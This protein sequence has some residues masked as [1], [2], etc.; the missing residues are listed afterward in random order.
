MGRQVG[1]N[2]NLPR[3]AQ[4]SRQDRSRESVRRQ[5]PRTHGQGQPQWRDSQVVS[6]LRRTTEAIRCE[7]RNRQRT[8][9]R[10]RTARRRLP[11]CR[12]FDGQDGSKRRAGC[13]P[14]HEL[15]RSGPRLEQAQ[16]HRSI[17]R[18]AGCRPGGIEPRRFSGRRPTTRSSGKSRGSKSCSSSA[19]FRTRCRWLRRERWSGSRISPTTRSM[20]ACR[21]FKAGR[22][23]SS[24]VTRQSRNPRRERC[25]GFPMR[26][27]CPLRL[28]S[29][30]SIPSKAF[31]SCWSPNA[32]TQRHCAW[33][34]T[35][36]GV[37]GQE[38]AGR[39]TGPPCNE[40]KERRRGARRKMR[41]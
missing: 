36:S 23:M 15:H 19:P 37:V 9:H 11:H 39:R 29:T 40:T 3:G 4:R 13:E 31:S 30:S 5:H 1:N 24:P 26:R 2:R 34:S 41:T 22:S 8:I 27:W 18:D 28:V 38:R 21:K 12:D 16:L 14:R 7:A 6:G 33:C 20:D 35:I 25:S 32:A 10:K 17:E